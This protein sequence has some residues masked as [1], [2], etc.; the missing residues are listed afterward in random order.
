MK[1]LARRKDSSFNS[2]PLT[3]EVGQKSAITSITRQIKQE[4]KTLCSED[5]NSLL[6]DGIEAVKHFSWERVWLEL[7]KSVPTLT[8]LLMKLVKR[9]RENQPLICLLSSMIV[10]Q[11]SP[12]L[13]LVQRAIT[14]ALYGNGTHKSV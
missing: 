1:R 3:L 2:A 12:K 6:R 13:G 10:K 8:S 5:N 9:P 4:L 7:E 14:V 11:R